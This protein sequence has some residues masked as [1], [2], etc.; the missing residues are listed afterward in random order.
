MRFTNNPYEGFM[1]EKSYFKGV[2]PSLPPKG[3]R[4]DGCPTGA[5]SAACSAT[6][7]SSNHRATGGDAVGRELTRTEKAA[8]RRLVS[9]WCANYDRDCG[10]LPLDCECYMFGKCWTGAYCRYFR[11]AVLPLDPALEA[12]L[13]AEGPSRIQ[14]LPGMRQSRGS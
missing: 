3:S 6:G 12:A 5:G 7:S 4:C 10:C 11:E 9:K 8:I 2:P 13:L 14:G 1:K